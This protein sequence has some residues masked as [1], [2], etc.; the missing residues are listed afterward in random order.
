[1]GVVDN[2]P[3]AATQIGSLIVGTAQ[4]QEVA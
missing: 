2:G 3:H 4:P 1:V